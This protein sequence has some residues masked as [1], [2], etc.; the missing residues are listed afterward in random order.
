MME[1]ARKFERGFAV[2]GLVLSSLF[3][4]C[5]V[6]DIAHSYENPG[7]TPTLVHN[8]IVYAR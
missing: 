3:V 6:A 7:R 4:A 5:F 8:V 2:L 1:F